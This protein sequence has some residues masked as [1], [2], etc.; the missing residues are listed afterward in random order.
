MRFPKTIF[1]N[2]QSYY[3][4][5]QIIYLLISNN[6]NYHKIQYTLKM[7]YFKKAADKVYTMSQN[8]LK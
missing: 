4:K 8:V 2:L 7:W 5:Y 3:L 1:I 6:T